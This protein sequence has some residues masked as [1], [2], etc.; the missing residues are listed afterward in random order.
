MT[1]D[2]YTEL[3][4]YAIRDDRVVNGL[5][6]AVT[7]CRRLQS[8]WHKFTADHSLYLT[9]NRDICNLI[10]EQLQRLEIAQAMHIEAIMLSELGP[11]PP[12]FDDI[13]F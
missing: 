11:P 6:S 4:A 9:M 10:E 5:M 3:A 7:D 12:L 13:M 8:E 1:H 2:E